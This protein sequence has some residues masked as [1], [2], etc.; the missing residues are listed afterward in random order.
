MNTSAMSQSSIPELCIGILTDDALAIFFS[1][2]PTDNLIE[3]VHLVL[4]G[5]FYRFLNYHVANVQG[6]DVALGVL[7]HLKSHGQVVFAVGIR[8]VEVVIVRRVRYTL[9]QRLTGLW[10]HDQGIDGHRSK[11]Q[12]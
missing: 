7:F 8:Y 3:P 6:I 9:T 4:A 2:P 10:R 5:C 11:G 1:E 12:G